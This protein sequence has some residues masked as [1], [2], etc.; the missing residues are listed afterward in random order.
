MKLAVRGVVE[1]LDWAGI[2]VAEVDDNNFVQMCFA[3][4][5]NSD[6][7]Y[8][9]FYLVNGKNKGEWFEVLF[10]DPEFRLNKSRAYELYWGLE[11]KLFAL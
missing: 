10:D 1:E 3:N 5:T 4:T 6:D 2:E 7:Y 8:N 11:T 9:R